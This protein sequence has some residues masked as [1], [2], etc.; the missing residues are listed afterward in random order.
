M[1]FESESGAEWPST[2]TGSSLLFRNVAIG[3]AVVVSLLLGAYGFF[4][5]MPRSAAGGIL[6]VWGVTAAILAGY[7]TSGHLRILFVTGGVIVSGVGMYGFF[8]SA[9]WHSMGERDGMLWLVL[10]GFESDATDAI[11]IAVWQNGIL[12]SEGTLEGDGV[13]LSRVKVPYTWNHQIIGGNGSVNVD[14]LQIRLA[15]SER[16]KV[17]ALGETTSHVTTCGLSQDGSDPI[18]IYCRVAAP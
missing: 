7:F 10:E 13:Y 2:P 9:D 6:F 14:G 15:T 12:H 16:V 18:L 5:M 3:I 17:V 4:L 11:R 8:C 1:S